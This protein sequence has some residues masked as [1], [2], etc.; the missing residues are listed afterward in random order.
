MDVER[1]LVVELERRVG[2]LEQELDGWNR[3][4]ESET[5]GMGIH[6]SQVDAV[7]VLYQMF[8]DK[9]ASRLQAVVQAE[10]TAVFPAKVI[11]LEQQLMGS[12]GV[13]AVFR[14][15]LGQRSD[16]R[17][18]RRVL[19]A[20]DFVAEDCYRTCM[21]A[22]VAWGAIDPN[23]VRVP[24]MTYLNTMYSPAAISRAGS[25]GAFKM[26]VE[27]NRDL[28][29]PIGVLSLPFHHTEAIWTFCS[30]YHEVGHLVDADLGLRGELRAALESA[31]EPDHQA[32]WAGRLRELVADTFG[33]LLGG[34]GFVRTMV[35]LLYQPPG[36][37][38]AI[39]TQDPDHPNPY[40]RVVLLCEL[41]GRLGNQ[42][43]AATSDS[44]RSL[45][46]S[47]YDLPPDLG[48]RVGECVTVAGVLLDQPLPALG[49]QSIRALAPPDTVGRDETRVFELARYLRTGTQRPNLR[50][51][52]K[53]FPMRLV[54]A[55]AQVAV[56][57]VD[58]APA[59]GFADIHARS[60]DFI[61]ALRR[62]QPIFLAGQG[63]SP[64]RRKGLR[65]LAE[66]IDVNALQD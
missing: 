23:Q 27:G 54:P 47:L 26:P 42:R 2:L 59:S 14:M 31:L 41:L 16:E 13:M 55:A 33:V 49:D 15:I 10:G 1:Q 61:G 34:E 30:L 64:D 3:L 32:Y 44:I 22:A 25:F 12:H 53:P 50:P 9:Q 60:L 28:P 8:K 56:G 62:Q 48:A 52:G 39:E 18:Y 20:A 4:T 46:L 66:R 40:V 29:L 21:N 36:T 11:A 17:F 65:A 7:E 43:L 35:K 38:A 19:D 63:L 6:R 51:G 58:A 24:P 37:A 57:E 45:W 5:S